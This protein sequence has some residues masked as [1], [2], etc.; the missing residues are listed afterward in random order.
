MFDGSLALAAFTCDGSYAERTNWC[1]EEFDRLFYEAE[2]ELGG[3]RRA[4]L[5][6]EAFYIV[7]EERPMIALFQLE[8]LVGVNANVDTAGLSPSASSTTPMNA[9]HVAFAGTGA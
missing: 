4:E 6:R 5:L 9:C 2:V 1:N 7:V 3:E 8:N